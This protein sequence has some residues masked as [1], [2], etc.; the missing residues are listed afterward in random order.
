MSQRNSKA[1]TNSEPCLLSGVAVSKNQRD[2]RDRRVPVSNQK[3][4]KRRELKEL[5]TGF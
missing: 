1:F 2:K 3:M 4:A 5:K